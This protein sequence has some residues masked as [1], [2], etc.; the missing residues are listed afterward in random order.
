MVHRNAPDRIVSGMFGKSGLL[1][2]AVV[3]EVSRSASVLYST[4]PSLAES[5]AALVTRWSFGLATPRHV[6]KIAV[7][8]VFGVHGAFGQSV[9]LPAMVEPPTAPEELLRL[10]VIV[11]VL[12]MVEHMR[13]EFAILSPVVHRWI[14][15]SVL[16]QSGGLARPVVM[17]S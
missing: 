2:V 14:A 10:L 17:A 13:R 6:V 4:C 1:A 15:K 16:G 8:M 11:G 5:V 7:K 9:L 3:V 12:P